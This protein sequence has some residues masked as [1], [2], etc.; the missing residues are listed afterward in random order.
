MGPCCGSTNQ[1]SGVTV[2]LIRSFWATHEAH[3]GSNRDPFGCIQSRI[4][5]LQSRMREPGCK[6]ALVEPERKF[7]TPAQVLRHIP[8]I[9]LVHKSHAGTRGIWEAFEIRGRAL[10]C[11]AFGS[12]YDITRDPSLPG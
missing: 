8:Y 11:A 6:R 12:A 5:L 2:A 1:L 10:P 7:C 4:S 9:V 3:P